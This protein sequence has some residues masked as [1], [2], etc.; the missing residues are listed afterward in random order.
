MLCLL[1]PF[2]GSCS[3]DGP[4]NAAAR[5]RRDDDPVVFIRQWYLNAW[6]MGHRPGSNNWCVRYLSKKKIPPKRWRIRREALA[7]RRVSCHRS[8]HV[9]RVDVKKRYHR[10]LTRS[11][12]AEL[13]EASPTQGT[14]SETTVIITDFL[15]ATESRS[16]MLSAQPLTAK[17]DTRMSE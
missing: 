11:L 4:H 6:R 13:G 12:P 10:S 5:G 1:P 3:C 14:L 7:P 16:A 8:Q 15:I 9:K 17:F 2:I